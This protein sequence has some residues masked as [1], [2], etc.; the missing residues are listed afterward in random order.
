MRIVIDFQGAQNESRFRG[1]GRYTISLTKALLRNNTD[2]EIIIVLNSIFP[3]SI[4]AIHLLFQGLI[5]QENIRIW[6]SPPSVG[7]IGKKN[8]WRREAAEMLREAFLLSLEPDLILISSL[9]EGAGDDVVTSIGKFTSQIPTAVILYDLIP[10]LN[11][12]EYLGKA[13]MERWY[14]EKISYL[15]KADLCFAISES[16]RQEAISHLK[17]SASTVID[18]STAIDERF[19]HSELVENT[20]KPDLK[21]WHIDRPF[22]LYSGAS[23]PRKNHIRL[24][25]AYASLPAAIRQSHQLVFAGVMP[26]VHI[27]AFQKHAQ[28]AGLMGNEL[29]I[30][31][32]IN[33]DELVEFYRSCRCFV[34]PSWHEGFGLPALEAMAGG[35]PV[36]GSNTSSIPE[37]IGNHDALFDPF[38]EVSIAAKILQVLTDQDFRESLIDKGLTQSRKFSWDMTAKRA[39]AAIALHFKANT[40]ASRQ[41][42]EAQKRES[43]LRLVEGLSRAIAE[44]QSSPPDKSAITN[45]AQCINLNFNSGMSEHELVLKIQALRR[46]RQANRIA[47][48][49][50]SLIKKCITRIGR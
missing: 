3:E 47:F 13:A 6:T 40:F 2:D 1:I 43:D 45:L 9:F 23:D 15:T 34:F 39:L 38:D 17:L 48:F 27:L 46:N 4:E 35:A 37:V 32:Y 24:I 20:S 26:Q 18:I 50:R 5:S 29:V 41:L 14:M 8:R 7:H 25:N 16:T 33:D 10:L 44:L 22:V 19:C 21:K 30:T 36:I 31:G 12:E 11:K 42:S 28:A 49:F